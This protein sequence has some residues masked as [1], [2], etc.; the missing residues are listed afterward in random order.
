[1]ADSSVRVSGIV[2]ASLMFQH[3]NSDSDV[4]GLIL[5]EIK[6]E[7]RTTISDSHID[8]I[9]FE[10]IIDIQKHI[11]CHKL[12]NFYSGVGEVNLDIM[13]QILSDNKQNVI[14]WYRQRRN[15]DQQMT[16]REK[17]VHENLKKALPN[18]EIIFLLLTPSELT[19]LGSTHR[20]EYAVFRSHS[21]RFKTVPVLVNNLGMLEQQAYWK[22]SAPCSAAGYERAIQQHKS[23]F[24]L[25][26]SLKEVNKVN[27]MNDSLQFELQTA[28]T[29]VEESERLVQKLLA[30]V[31]TLRKT[32]SKKRRLAL[33]K[34]SDALRPVP[35]RNVPL[36]E[37]LKAMFPCSPQLQTQTLTLQGIPVP[38]S[39]C[40]TYHG[41]D[42]AA[43]PKPKMAQS[44]RGFMSVTHKRPQFKKN[45]SV[46]NVIHLD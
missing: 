4:E 30:D 22:F 12:N 9:H 23:R 1:M 37:A 34:D 25:N 15:T 10:H 44:R 29:H 20:M 41:I 46:C 16:F 38:E 40:S 17:V 7:E 27:G 35:K 33:G 2:L 5:G 31:T 45:P 8:H 43:D 13:R 24:F 42:I 32:I 21:R 39:S 3:C 11:P 19:S 6:H 28:C 18:P 26:G 14:G 36:C